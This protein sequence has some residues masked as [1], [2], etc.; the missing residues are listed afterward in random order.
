MAVRKQYSEQKRAL[1][2]NKIKYEYLDIV[3]LRIKSYNA[4]LLFKGVGMHKISPVQWAWIN[5]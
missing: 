1:L 5:A 4:L 3:L 2:K